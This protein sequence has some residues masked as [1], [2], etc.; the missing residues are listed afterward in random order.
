MNQY[1]PNIHE[2]VLTRLAKHL[3]FNRNDAYHKI[4]SLMPKRYR[5]VETTCPLTGQPTMAQSG[6]NLDALNFINM[7]I[8]DWEAVDRS[9]LRQYAWT[10]DYGGVKA[11]STTSTHHFSAREFIGLALHLLGIQKK[12]TRISA[13]MTD[14]IWLSSPPNNLGYDDYDTI[15]CTEKQAEALHRM[16]MTYQKDLEKAYQRGFANGSEFLTAMAEGTLTIDQINDFE[17]RRQ[18]AKAYGE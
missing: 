10:Y 12:R 5:K 2:T 17:V 8:A 9:A 18:K 6:L 3:G 7:A 14:V 11:T 15:F 4:V 16:V 13:A 1:L